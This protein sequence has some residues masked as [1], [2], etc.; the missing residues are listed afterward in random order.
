MIGGPV[1]VLKTQIM[2]G[3]YDGKTKKSVVLSQNSWSGIPIEIERSL[4]LQ[5]SPGKTFDHFP[6]G[7]NRK[8]IV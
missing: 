2:G 1:Y 8:T 3:L 4:R 5:M 7:N 6:K